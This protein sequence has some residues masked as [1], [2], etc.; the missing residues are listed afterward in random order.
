[1]VEQDKH[2]VML[3]SGLCSLEEADRT[4]EKYGVENMVNVFADVKGS[5]TNPHDGEDEDNYRFLEEAVAYIGAPLIRVKHGLSVWEHF[6]KERM[7]GSSRSPLCSVDLKRDILDKWQQ[8]NCDPNHTILH[9][10]L[11]WDEPHRVDAIREAKAPWR[12]ECLSCEPPYLTK[13]QLIEKYKAKGICPPRLY[14]MGFPHANCGGFC[15]KAG[16]AQFAL[17]LRTMPERYAYHE[18]KEREFRAMVGKDVSILR[19]RR[20]GKTKTLTLQ[21]LRERLD[22]NLTIDFQEWGGCGCVIG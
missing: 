2:I 19:D 20:G 12:V 18:Q 10:G 16:Q 6:F 4:K 17:L 9:F 14:K 1:M 15:V 21:Q 22:A 8:E 3:S 13:P 5:S 11:G 7:M